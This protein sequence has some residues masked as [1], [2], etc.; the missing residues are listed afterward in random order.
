MPRIAL[1]RFRFFDPVRGRW[2][3]ARYRASEATI[4]ATYARY[5]L[6][7]EPEVREAPEDPLRITAG[8]VQRPPMAPDA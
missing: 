2:I 8:H 1:F 4:G 6:M 3:I 5:V 7:G